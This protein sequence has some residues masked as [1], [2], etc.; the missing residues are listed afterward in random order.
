MSKALDFIIFESIDSTNTYLKRKIKAGEITS[1]TVV[2]AKSQTNGR[3]RLERNW[4]AEKGKSLTVSIALKCPPNPSL[5]LLCALGVF[6]ALDD[7]LGDKNLKIKWPNDLVRKG[8]KLCGI[9]CERVSDFTVIGIGINA[10]N[11][12]FPEEIKEKATSL[13]LLT[14]RE[15]N[16]ESL[17]KS[18]CEKVVNTLE[19]HRFALDENARDKY[20]S[21]CINLGKEVHFGSPLKKGI[22]VDISPLGEL[23]VATESGYENVSYGDV[24]V[25]GIY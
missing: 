24:F 5:T 11:R 8:R 7:I 1:D 16:I 17:A 9:L 19:K 18:V 14:G 21:L 6:E 22:A 13:T 12:I 15:Y 4:E 3:G 20:K 2:L 25:S 10:N 23:V